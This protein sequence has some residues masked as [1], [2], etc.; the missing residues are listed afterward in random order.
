MA[1]PSAF[2]SVYLMVTACAGELQVILPSSPVETPPNLELSRVFPSRT[3]LFEPG[4]YSNDPAYEPPKPLLRHVP[5]AT[6]SIPPGHYELWV[7]LVIEKDGSIGEARVMRGT[8]LPAVD[9]ACLAA[10]LKGRFSPAK[11]KGEP[12]PSTA[13]QPYAFDAR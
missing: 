4:T 13:W 5:H 12:V 8:G 3:D 9:D 10:A 1:R 11:L 6:T 2:L 7:L